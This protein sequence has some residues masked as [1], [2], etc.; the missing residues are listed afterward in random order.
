M[1][2]I[3]RAACR[4]QVPQWMK[5]TEVFKSDSDAQFL[6]CAGVTGFTRT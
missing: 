6:E 2:L 4:L 1:A 3:Y 5:V